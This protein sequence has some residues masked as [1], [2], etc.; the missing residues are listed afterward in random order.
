LALRRFG[1]AL[2]A[3]RLLAGRRFADTLRLRD[4]AFAFRANFFFV[5]LRLFAMI[6]L[7]TL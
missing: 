3:G 1:C 7:Q 2:L 6:L 5:A 4:A